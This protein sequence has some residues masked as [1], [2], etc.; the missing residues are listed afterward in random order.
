MK[1]FFS[2]LALMIGS[3]LMVV[4][5]H[6]D[7]DSRRSFAEER[8]LY[9]NSSLQIQLADNNPIVVKIDRTPF[10]RAS[11]IMRFG[12][13]PPRRYRIKIFGDSPFGMTRKNL[14]YDGYIRV[15]PDVAY[16]AIL[17]PRN[18]RLKLES[19]LIDKKYRNDKVYEESYYDYEKST[20]KNY[21][22]YDDEEQPSPNRKYYNNRKQNLNDSH[23]QEIKSSVDDRPFAS[24]KIK[25][26][27]TA[28]QNYNYNSTHIKTMAE[29]LSYDSDKLE[30]AKWAYASVSDPRNYWRIETVFTFSSTKD[31]FGKFLEAQGSRR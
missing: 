5:Q 22:R 13:L 18:G 30:F 10:T 11:S 3:S 15:E 14:L 20:H 21:D 17:N 28:L 4:A 6:R 1:V 27:K 26:L 8:N 31:D 29:W 9:Y 2:T 7:D 25:S 12:N 19:T 24:D 23:V 16:T